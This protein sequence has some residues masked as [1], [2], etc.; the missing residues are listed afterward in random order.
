MN[1]KNKKVTV[2]GLGKSG[3]AAAK[4]LFS[5]K[6]RVRVTDSSDKK[7]ILENAGYYVKA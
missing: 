5:Q 6:A 7:E 2:I 1:F 4:F 3:F